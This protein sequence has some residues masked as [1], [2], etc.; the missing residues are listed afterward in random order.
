MARH[1]PGPF[2]APMLHYPEGVVVLLEDGPELDGGEGPRHYQ[3]RGAAV[4]PAEDT[5][6]DAGDKEDPE[7]LQMGVAVEGPGQHLLGGDE[8]CRETAG[9]IWI[10]MSKARGLR[11]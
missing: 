4:Q 8:G 1:I 5:R 9:R 2:V 11:R 6:A 10:S 3:V 7:L